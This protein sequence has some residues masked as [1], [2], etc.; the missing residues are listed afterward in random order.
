MIKI[1][2]MEMSKG[3]LLFALVCLALVIIE[4][5]VNPL[6]FLVAVIVAVLAQIL[7]SDDDLFPLRLVLI[8]VIML[9]YNIVG[10]L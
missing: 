4:I 10:S 2:E 3:A 8:M 7:L 9:I 5:V 1:G 6:R